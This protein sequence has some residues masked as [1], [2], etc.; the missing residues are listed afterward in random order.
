MFNRCGNL[1]LAGALFLTTGSQWVVLQSIAWTG[2]VVSY[3]EKAP[4]K[5]ALM[6][7]FDGK[8]PCCLC[9]TIA[10]AKKAGTK[11]H[12]TLLVKKLQFAPAPENFALRAPTQFQFLPRANHAFGA[13]LPHKPL[14]PPPRTFLV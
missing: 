2:M 3:A 1:V 7:T 10:A 12:Y 5:V 4:L 13:S 9:K 8:H 11:S 14:V 6:E